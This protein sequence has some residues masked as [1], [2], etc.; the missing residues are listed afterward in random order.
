MTDEEIAGLA[1]SDV[2]APSSLLVMWA[3]WPKLDVALRVA[4]RWGFRLKTGAAWVKTTD[5]FRPATGT[6]WWVRGSTEPILIATR[7]AP[8]PPSN[9][10]LGVVGQFGEWEE[11]SLWPLA[12]P[13]SRHSEKPTD[14]HRLAEALSERVGTRRLEMFARKPRPGWT[15]WGNEVE[16]AA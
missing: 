5:A 1:V 6:G 4:E 7:G 2:V 14:I 10:P 9:P 16:D 11:L 13:R 3:T 15:C 8:K 12:A